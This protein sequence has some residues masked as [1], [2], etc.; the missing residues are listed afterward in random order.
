[1]QGT[2]QWDHTSPP[3]TSMRTNFYR[4]FRAS[5]GSPMGIAVDGSGV[6]RPVD[7]L[8]VTDNPRR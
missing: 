8:V 2:Q 4:R 7:G 5:P 1:M 6:V 3:S